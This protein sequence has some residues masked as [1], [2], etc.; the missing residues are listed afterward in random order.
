MICY[1]ITKITEQ[2]VR[3]SLLIRLIA[4]VFFGNRHYPKLLNHH[5]NISAA[6]LNE[7]LISSIVWQT[8][9]YGHGIGGGGHTHVFLV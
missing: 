9:I 7:A 6:I 2:A 4:F 1:Y 8:Q 5:G 3:F